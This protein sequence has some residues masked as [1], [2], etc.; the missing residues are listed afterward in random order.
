MGLPG[1][2]GAEKALPKNGRI[3]ECCIR[4]IIGRAVGMDALERQRRAAPIM[5]RLGNR[6]VHLLRGE[7][8]GQA[9]AAVALT[10]GKRFRGFRFQPARIQPGKSSRGCTPFAR[11]L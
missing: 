3:E 9:E 10:E 8:T 6:D 11:G 5:G 1:I 4:R 2:P 7:G